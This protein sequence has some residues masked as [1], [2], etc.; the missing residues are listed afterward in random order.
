MAIEKQRLKDQEDLE[1]FRKG[2]VKQELMKQ[3]R[4]DYA[5]K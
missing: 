3:K 4:A 2:Q 1:C 5:K